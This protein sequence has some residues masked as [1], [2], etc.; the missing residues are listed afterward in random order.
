MSLFLT[1]AF[2]FFIG[3]VSGWVLELF[4]RRFIS[5]ANPERKWINPGFCTGPYLP[6]YGTG[7]CLLYL[8]ASLDTVFPKISRFIIFLLMA[9]SMTVIEYIAGIWCLKKTKVRLWDY[10]DEWGNIEGVICPKFSLYWALIGAGYYFWV[11]SHILNALNW[12]SNNLTFSFVIGMFYGIFL[13]DYVQSAKLISRF[14]AFAVENNVVLR[15]DEI[16][17]Q[18]RSHHERTKQKYHFFHPFYSERP[19]SEYLKEMLTGIESIKQKMKEP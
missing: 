16:K 8:I 3:S 19:L 17:M 13:L 11:H 10:S 18:I 12:L 15:Y 2:L 9:I 4:Y 7:L 14:K 1:L 5:S 6:L